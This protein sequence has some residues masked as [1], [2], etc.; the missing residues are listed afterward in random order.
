M[1]KL[2]MLYLVSSAVHVFGTAQNTQV[3][4]VKLSIFCLFMLVKLL[5]YAGKN[6]YFKNN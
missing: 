2:W 5:V 3:L 1:D 6:D 4:A